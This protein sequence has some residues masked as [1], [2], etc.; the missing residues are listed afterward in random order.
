MPVKYGSLPFDAQ[1]KFF[2]DKINLPTKAWTDIWEKEHA[3]AFVVAGATNA[4]LLTDLRSAV[5]RA[6]ADGTTLAQ[7]RKD[8]DKTVLKHGWSYKGERSWRTRVIYETN[9][10]TSYAA[11]RYKQ[12]QAVKKSRPYWRYKHSTAVAVPRQ[13]HLD[14]DGLILAADDPWWDIHYP[15]NGWGCRCKVFSLSEADLKSLG[16]TRP[17]KAPAVHHREVTVGSNGPS[18]RTVSVPEG[19]DPGWAHNVGKAAWGE[20]LSADAMAEWGG[21]SEVWKRLTP[22]TW[23]SYGRAASLPLVPPTTKLGHRVDN[24]DDVVAA[25]RDTIGGDDAVYRTAGLPVH[26]NA[27]TLGEHIDPS[28][29]EY[30]PLLPELLNDPHEVWLSFEEH[31]GSGK[32]RLR[33]RILKAFDI[34]KGRSVLFVA[35][36]SR[37]MLEGWTVVPMNAQRN[38]NYINRQRTGWLIYGEK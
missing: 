20:Q 21:S 30:I 33:S 9:L 13:S 32:V 4:E 12:L 28:R 24:V 26:I 19:V 34:G 1:I 3:R 18:P 38:R 36:A 29:A 16:R 25:V 14:W 6:I 31:Q 23:E 17:H 35:N 27:R 22:G 7:F 5:D 15:P 37:G 11:G 2:R 10:R 8:F